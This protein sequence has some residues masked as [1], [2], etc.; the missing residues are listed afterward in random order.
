M[1]VCVCVGG[2]GGGGGGDRGLFYVVVLN[3]ELNT[4][5]FSCQ[6]NKILEEYFHRQHF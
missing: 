5:S 2:G 3:S 4:K 6:T 1:C